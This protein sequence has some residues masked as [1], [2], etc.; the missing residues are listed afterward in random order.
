MIK[1]AHFFQ[2]LDL[3]IVSTSCPTAKSLSATIAR[4]DGIPTLAPA[5]WSF[6]KRTNINFGTLFVE[7]S[8]S[9]SRFHVVNRDGSL[10]GPKVG[11]CFGAG[12]SPCFMPASLSANERS[13]WRYPVW[14]TP[15]S[16]FLTGEFDWPSAP[17][18]AVLRGSSTSSVKNP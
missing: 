13:Y 17:S 1:I 2:M 11:V 4:G 10:S 5:V 3:E 16:A 9:K 7:T 14:V 15:R 8:L 12:G 6:P 18:S